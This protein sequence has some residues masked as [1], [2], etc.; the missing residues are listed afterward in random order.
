MSAIVPAQ[1]Y[2]NAVAENARL[3]ERMAALQSQLDTAQQQLEAAQ[4]QL[5]WF[6]R[7]LFGAKTEKR[8]E[9]DPALGRGELALRRFKLR[10]QGR[11]LGHGIVVFLF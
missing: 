3:R 6:K 1:T 5:D 4:H 9:I 2:D 7:Q 10:L 8:L 11:I